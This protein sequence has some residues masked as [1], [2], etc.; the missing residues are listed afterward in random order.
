MLGTNSCWLEPQ[1]KREGVILSGE[2]SSAFKEEQESAPGEEGDGIKG[3]FSLKGQQRQRPEA[4]TASA[5]FRNSE[6][7]SVAEV[8]PLLPSAQYWAFVNNPRWPP[9][10][11]HSLTLQALSQ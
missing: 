8:C 7:S 1:T 10:V 5:V 2:R 6:T 9:G 11:S 4:V 3:H